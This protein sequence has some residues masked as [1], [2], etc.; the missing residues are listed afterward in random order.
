MEGL[1]DILNSV[2]NKSNH[3]SDKDEIQALADSIKVS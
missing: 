3:K 2:A 1:V